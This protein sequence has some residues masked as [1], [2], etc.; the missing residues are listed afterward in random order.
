[1]GTERLPHSP[2]GTE[3]DVGRLFAFWQFL[4]LSQTHLRESDKIIQQE[5]RNEKNGTVN[6]TVGVQI[7]LG[8]ELLSVS[9]ILK[10]SVKVEMLRCLTHSGQQRNILERN[11]M[12]STLTLS[13]NSP[14]K[15]WGKKTKGGR[16]RKGR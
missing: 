9:V 3:R 11:T 6:F 2:L 4:A 15:S 1:M 5:V 16:G 12:E 14:S 8:T 10:P 13:R 7:A